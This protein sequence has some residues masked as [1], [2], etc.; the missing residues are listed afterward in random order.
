[1]RLC[2]FHPFFSS[3]HRIQPTVTLLKL[4]SK[5]EIEKTLCISDVC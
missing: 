4:I 3:D 1:M 5:I 2:L